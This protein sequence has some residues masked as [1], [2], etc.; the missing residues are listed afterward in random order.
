M[1]KWK[2]RNRKKNGGRQEDG[3]GRNSP[4]KDVLLSRQPAFSAEK[5]CGLF[6][7]VYLK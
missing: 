6:E 7:G 4:L 2:L 3:R 1:V 5:T